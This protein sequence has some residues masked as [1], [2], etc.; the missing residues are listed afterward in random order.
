MGRAGR[1]S[2]RKKG[3]IGDYPVGYGKPPAHSRWPKGQSGCPSGGGTKKKK[4]TLQDE[5]ERILAEKVTVVE[6]GKRRRVSMGEAL[7]RRLFADALRGEKKAAEMVLNLMKAVDSGEFGTTLVVNIS[8]R[9]A[10]L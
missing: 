3:I 7:M 5:L 9:D 2:H 4:S 1:S 10:D 6:G 8:P